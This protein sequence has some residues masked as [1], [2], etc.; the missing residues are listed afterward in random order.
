MILT[1][2]TNIRNAV[3]ILVTD[4]I[5]ETESVNSR[6]MLRYL[7]RGEKRVKRPLG[8]TAQHQEMIGR[9]HEVKAQRECEK[10]GFKGTNI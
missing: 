8:F 4:L 3:E 10:K 9:H 5:K 2:M 6:H 1:G 7:V